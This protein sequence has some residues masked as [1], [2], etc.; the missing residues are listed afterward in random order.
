MIT[1][2]LAVALAAADRPRRLV[3]VEVGHLAV[4]QHRRVVGL[5]DRLD[6]LAAVAH[7]VGAEAALVEHPHGEQLVDLAVLGDEDQRRLLAE[8][9]AAVALAERG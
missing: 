3:A 9:A 6:R 1:M 5:G 4:H 7:D 8:H 2:P